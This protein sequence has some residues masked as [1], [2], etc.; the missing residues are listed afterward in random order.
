M[1]LAGDAILSAAPPRKAGS[2]SAVT[3]TANEL[4]VVL[5]IAVLGSLVTAV[6]RS[7]L[8]LPETLPETVRA[9]A[10]DS[11]GSALAVLEPGSAP[12]QAAR[13]AFLTAMQTT[14]LVAAGLTLA[15]AALAWWLIPSPR[16]SR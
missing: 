3:E 13:D 2:V 14:S 16:G 12:A 4:G 11:L 10:E 8:V 1:T 9:R 15:A 6:Y 7:K 5:G